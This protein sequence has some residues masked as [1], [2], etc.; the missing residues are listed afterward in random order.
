MAESFE[1][2]FSQ[3][4]VGVR[5]TFEENVGVDSALDAGTKSVANDHLLDGLNKYGYGYHFHDQL[6]FHATV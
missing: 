1:W 6:M 3:R 5:L 2:A 4:S